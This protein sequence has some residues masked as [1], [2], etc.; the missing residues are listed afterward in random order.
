MHVQRLLAMPLPELPA[1]V[2]GPEPAE[3]SCNEQEPPLHVPAAPQ[4]AALQPAKLAV[5]RL[6]MEQVGPEYAKSYNQALAP[7]PRLLGSRCQ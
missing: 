5:W 7:G 2:R 6:F 3:D 4:Q 1:C